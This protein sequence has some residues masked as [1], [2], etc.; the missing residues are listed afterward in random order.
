MFLWSR[1][2]VWLSN[3]LE[4]SIKQQATIWKYWEILKKKSNTQRVLMPTQRKLPSWYFSFLFNIMFKFL[5]ESISTDSIHPRTPSRS[6]R[7]TFLSKIAH[8]SLFQIFFQSLVH[9]LVQTFQLC[10]KRFC[11]S[12]YLFFGLV[13]STQFY[14]KLQCNLLLTIS[15]Y[16]PIVLYH[17]TQQIK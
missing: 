5:H 8:S 12:M 1:K 2:Q 13:Q 9:Y 16:C 10:F 7:C 6:K 4:K 14:R 3:E 17:D 11:L 15:C